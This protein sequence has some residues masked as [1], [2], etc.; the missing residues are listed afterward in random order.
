MK[1]CLV[2]PN[3][4][5]LSG[6]INA[7][8]SKSQT[9]RAI[10]FAT[11]ANGKSHI[12]NILLSPDAMAMIS[13]C[14]QL[15]AMIEQNEN[16][17]KIIGTNGKL[18]IPDD[19]IDAGNSGIVLRFIA[20]ICSN[21]NSYAVITGDHSIRH[22][23]PVKPLLDGLHGLGVFAESMR[24]D[25]FAP[26]IIKGPVLFDSTQ[27]DGHDSQPVS[28][29]IISSLLSNGNTEIKVNHP[30]EKPWLDLTLDWLD[31]L[32]L[33]Y[34]RDGYDRFVI[35]GIQ[36]INNFDYFVPS[37]LSSI[38][39]PV[40][41]ALVTNSSI[42]INNVDL[43]DPQGDKLLIDIFRQMGAK[44]DYHEHTKKLIVNHYD[45]LVGI[46]VDINNCID[47]INILSVV[48][49]FAQG[50]TK[51]TGAK[52]ARSKECDRIACISAELTRMGASLKEFDDGLSIYNSTLR[53]VDGLNTY[54]D[55]RMVMALFVAA[56]GASFNNNHKNNSTILGISSI[57]KSYPEFFDH[58]QAIGCDFILS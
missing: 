20:S 11:L 7:S 29:L 36:I 24:G 37:D 46:E 19:I 35:P 34:S 43:S 57:S 6:E 12:E 42:V 15:G 5:K 28:G 45:K 47:V 33:K 10:L 30:G 41:A 44:I 40:A 23:R 8:P 39:F 26:L 48:A 38:S 27:L 50:E 25:D 54:N 32:D 16:T 3:N 18:S 13:A 49:C 31:R 58:M 53:P 17:L 9:L 21:L 22:N 51:I 14:K 56:L 2:Y 55:H 52:I 4:N 1:K